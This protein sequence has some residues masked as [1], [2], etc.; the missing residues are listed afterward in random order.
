MTR[1]GR[2]LENHCNP[3]PSPIVQRFKFYRCVPTPGQ[4]IASFAANLTEISETCEFGPVLQEMLQDKLGMEVTDGTIQ[5]RLLFVEYEKLDFTKAFEIATS[6]ELTTSGAKN[7]QQ[8]ASS[9]VPAE[10]NK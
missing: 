4:S 8:R 10:V 9:L 7:I 6:I 2:A 1:L 3:K 5:K